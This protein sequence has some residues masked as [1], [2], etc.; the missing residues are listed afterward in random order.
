MSATKTL[1]FLEVLEVLDPPLVAKCIDDADG[2]QFRGAFLQ[3]VAVRGGSRPYA[4]FEM[5]RFATTF[6]CLMSLSTAMKSS[7][8]DLAGVY[9]GAFFQH[10]M[11]KGE[12]RTQAT[13]KLELF[14]IIMTG[15]QLLS[16]VE[17]SLILDGTYR[18]S[19]ISMFQMC[20]S[21]R[22]NNAP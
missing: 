6:T 11:V 14:M 3:R 22:R 10:L 1:S 16:F 17:K 8:L 7:I 4:A 20:S 12:S 21:Q 15:L 5:E 13:I 19:F 18:V 2:R 9:L